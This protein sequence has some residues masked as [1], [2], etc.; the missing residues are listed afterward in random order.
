VY[1]LPEIRGW[2]LVVIYPGVRVSTSE[3]Y[4][5]LSSSLTSGQAI[6]K[7]Y[8]FCTRLEAQ[9]DWPGGIFNDFET[10]ILPAFPAIREARDF[11]RERGASAVHLSGSGSSVFGFFPEEE[12]ALAAARGGLP[13]ESWRAFP[14]KTL[15]RAEYLQGIFGVS[16]ANLD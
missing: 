4:R 8:G 15:S 6:H 1:P 16:P 2:P 14:A 12:S 13:E 10:S 11:L 3:A 9:A 7:M 5:S